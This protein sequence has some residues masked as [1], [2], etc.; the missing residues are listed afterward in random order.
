MLECMKFKMIACYFFCGINDV[1]L[2]SCEMAIGWL[3][4]WLV[5]KEVKCSIPFCDTLL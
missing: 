4:L 5:T 3:M 1:T 2:S